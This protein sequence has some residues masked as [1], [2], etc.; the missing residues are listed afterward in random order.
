MKAARLMTLSLLLAIAVGAVTM[1]PAS[2]HA[3]D[4]AGSWT[5]TVVV[6][7]PGCQFT[8]PMEVVATGAMTFR[9]SAMLSLVPGSNS[10][11]P[12]SFTGMG[13]GTLEGNEI[14]FGLADLSLGKVNFGGTVAD[15]GLSAMGDWESQELGMGT[16]FALRL[17]PQAASVCGSWTLDV[18][19][20]NPNC[21]LVGSM[22][23][24]QR[25]S[26]L[27]GT[28]SGR[29]ISGEDPCPLTGDANV[30]GALSG[31]TVRLG[32]VVPAEE[33]YAFFEG[34]LSDDRRTMTGM[35]KFDEDT[36]GTLTAQ[37]AGV[38]APAVGGMAV[39]ILGALLLV[40]GR[41]VLRRPA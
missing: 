39:G 41:R 7:K 15:D 30:V 16:W 5:L 4:V 33:G 3:V 21:E 28:T 31:S 8:G 40:G 12:S 20:M 35:W 23:L 34:M 18:I 11:C 29:R 32:L 25:G 14:V 27:R 2:V 36:S 19:S 13:E 22:T 17:S 9:G 10:D 24:T 1:R 6:P 37:C 26:E 38:A